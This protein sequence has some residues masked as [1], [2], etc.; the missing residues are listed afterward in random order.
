MASVYEQDHVTVDAGLAEGGATPLVGA[1]MAAKLK[2]PL[3][4][5]VA[6][7]VEALHAPRAIPVGGFFVPGE[8]KNDIRSSGYVR[9]V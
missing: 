7:T 8:C 4:T 3:Q 6:R 2:T 9:S 1:N 5:T